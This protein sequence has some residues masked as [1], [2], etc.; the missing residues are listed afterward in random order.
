MEKEEMTC[1]SLSGGQDK[2][3]GLVCAT[4]ARV[5]ASSPGNAHTFSI[6]CHI[7]LL[8]LRMNA[9]EGLQEGLQK[10]CSLLGGG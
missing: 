5:Q 6:L 9:E 7:C 8:T 1:T 3:T 4:V 2:G 10:G